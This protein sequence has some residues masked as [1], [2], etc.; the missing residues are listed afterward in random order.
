MS[1]T[2]VDLDT[3]RAAIKE[4]ESISLELEK[5]YTTGD[6][7]IKVEAAGEDRPSVV[8]NNWAV[9][10]GAAHQKSNDELR[11]VLLTRIQNL[12][13]TLAQYEQTEQGNKDNFKP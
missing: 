11:K 3:L 7:L 2:K 4:Y 5:A 1:G 9:T 10:A 8:Y 12:K 6:A 13:A